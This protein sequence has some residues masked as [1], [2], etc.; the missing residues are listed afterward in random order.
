M[1]YIKQDRREKILIHNPGFGP[2]E[3]DP[4]E[5][6]VKLIDVLKIENCGDLN[7]AFTVIL[8]DYWKNNPRYQTA[9]DII[10]A[11]E[12]AKMEFARR[13]VYPYEDEKISEN[14]DVE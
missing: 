4:G 12:G 11:L 6:E 8:N 10:G 2:T 14:G 7:F 5:D 1:P 13:Y 3:I 9:N